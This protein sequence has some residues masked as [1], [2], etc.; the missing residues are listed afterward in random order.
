MGESISLLMAIHCH[1]PVG[2]FDGVISYA[3][4]VSYLPFIEVLERHPK[5]RLSLHYTGP[6]LD[7]LSLNRP[8]F[9]DRIKALVEKGQV[10]ILS[11]GYYEP[12]L[13]LLR[14]QDAVAQVEKMNSY[15]YD[16]FGYKPSGAWLA[17]R[18]WEPKVPAILNRAGIG[19]TIVDDSHFSAVGRDVESLDGYYISEDEGLIIR[20]FPTSERLRYYMPF[21]LPEETISYLKEKKEQGVKAITFGD[22]G[23]KFGLWPGTHQWVYKEGWLDRF[24]SAIES[25]DWIETQ[26]FSDFINKNASSGMIYLPCVSYREMLEWSEGYFRNFLIKYP[27]SNKMHKR[28]LLVSQALAEFDPTHPAKTYLFMSQCNCGYWHGVFGGLYLN[29]LRSAIYS[30]LILAETTAGLNKDIFEIADINKDGIDEIVIGN[31]E[32]KIF[33]NQNG[34]A[35]EWDLYEPAVNISNVLS[36]RYEPYHEKLKKLNQPQK[37]TDGV[38]SIHDL[39]VS[40]VKDISTLKYD[41]YLRDSF[42][43]YFVKEN[44]SLA[45]FYSHNHRLELGLKLLKVDQR[46]GAVVINKQFWFREGILYVQKKLKLQDRGIIVNVS[47]ESEGVNLQDKCIFALEFNYSLYDSGLSTSKKLDLDLRK[48]LWFKDKWYG[49]NILHKSEKHFWVCYYPVETISE[50]EQGI[51]STYQGSCVILLWKLNS[52][53]DS[54]N[55]EVFIEKN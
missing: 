19:F 55:L 36:R 13:T 7:W 10:E 45:D 6:L 15:L 38:V 39:N 53:A 42:I 50:S 35:F 49:I 5:I 17:E 43:D 20:I 48:E 52:K 24:F 40:K 27:E 37:Q 23:E 4:E 9:L 11:G 51:E 33:L 3:Y 21:K 14:E 31:K 16:R 2:N 32:Q 12:I 34:E 8:E 26:T 30:N 22:D 47:L 28:M 46:D 54:F 41:R 25:Q 44:T 18:I 29:H 1:Q